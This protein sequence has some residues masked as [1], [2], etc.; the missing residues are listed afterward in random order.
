[1][2]N[3]RNLQQKNASFYIIFASADDRT[4]IKMKIALLQLKVKAT[5]VQTINQH[6]RISILLIS[7]RITTLATR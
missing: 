3:H 4:V 1:M 7:S 2:D 6:D 5:F